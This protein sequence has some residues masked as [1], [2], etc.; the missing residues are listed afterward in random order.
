MRAPRPFFSLDLAT[1]SALV[2]A[3]LLAR[4]A[5]SHWIVLHQVNMPALDQAWQSVLEGEPHWRA[6]QNRLLGPALLHA[7]GWLSGQPLVLFVKLAMLALN[8]ALF[9]MVRQCTGSALLGLFAVAVTMLMWT[10]QTHYW[11]YPWD[12]IEAGCLLAL[13]YVAMRGASMRW[14]LVLFAVALLNRESAVFF[15]IY[16]LAHGAARYRATRMFSTARRWVTWGLLLVVLTLVWTEALRHALFD[17]S[18]LAGVHD[19][20]QHALFGNHL[21]HLAN[22]DVVQQMLRQV[23]PLFF[24]IVMYG[25]ALAMVLRQAWRLNHPALIGVGSA[26]LAYFLSLIEFGYLSEARIYQPFAWCLPLMLAHAW[27]LPHSP[28][29]S[30]SK[31]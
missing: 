22:W 5:Y 3:L 9:L 31:A 23:Q 17:Y 25:L 10:V 11:S 2:L 1:A 13:V 12:F 20:R 21:N 30:P 7:L 24:V 15:G 27:Q 26:V 28:S 19:D 14:L 8:A 6:Y 4:M 16:M 18:S 29:P